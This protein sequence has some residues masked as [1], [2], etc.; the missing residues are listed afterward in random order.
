VTLNLGQ[1][2]G[3]LGDPKWY[4]SRA[5]SISGN[6]PVREFAAMDNAA[7]IISSRLIAGL[8]LY[9]GLGFVLSLWLGHRSLFMAVGA[10]V[11]LGL[12][13]YLIF[14]GLSREIKVIG[15]SAIRPTGSTFEGDR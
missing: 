6:A 13:Y 12:S 1:P 14:T 2:E 4:R 5:R 7:W 11:G 9:T 8:I 3:S 15:Q 10:L